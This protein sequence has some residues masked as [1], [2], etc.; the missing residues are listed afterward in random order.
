MISGRVGECS[1]DILPIVNGIVSE[2]GRVREMMGDYEAY[3]ASLGI[4]GIQT[5][6]NRSNI[7]EEFEVSELDLVYAE[8][9]SKFGQVEFP[10][11]AMCAF[12][13]AVKEKGMNVIPLDM[14]DDDF[15]QMY[16]DTVGVTDF[17]KEH[18]LAKKGMKKRFKLEDP[19]SFSRE[20]DEY[21]NTVKG[22]RETSR[23]REKY[24]ADQ[25]RDIARFKKSLLAVIEVERVD[26]VVSELG[27]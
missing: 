6:K 21:V 26:G 4:E 19:E 18:R 9:I 17:V 2:A 7:D 3:A 11:P 25:I 27:W 14:N 8:H 10:S 23:N 16:C 13:D 5:I 12:I 22:Y 1:V 24:M 15:T 20:W